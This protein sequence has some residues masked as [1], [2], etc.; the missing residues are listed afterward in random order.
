MSAKESLDPL[1]VSRESSVTDPNKIFEGLVM[2]IYPIS[3]VE[4]YNKESLAGVINSGN[5]T[6]SNSAM[7]GVDHSPQQRTSSDGH[8]PLSD[9]SG[10]SMMNAI[11]NRN[12]INNKQPG[13]KRDLAAAEMNSSKR[14]KGD[15][16]DTPNV[17]R[18]VDDSQ[19]S[20][21]LVG[22]QKKERETEEGKLMEEG[23]GVGL[24]VI[25]DDDDDIQ[26][27]DEDEI[28]EIDEEQLLDLSGEKGE[29]DQE[30]EEDNVEDDD[31]DDDDDDEDED[32]DE[33]EESIESTEVVQERRSSR[34]PC[35][36]ALALQLIGDL[37]SQITAP[38]RYN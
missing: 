2:P 13:N 17:S 23:E 27:I 10:T 7:D 4:T 36:S 32:E 8:V 33:D 3:H 24:M 35:P 9:S 1:T 19:I 20:T 29:D 15:I 25:Q 12:P 5:I 22:Q 34:P 11:L 28:F 26:E 30:N 18:S 37:P 31:D 38:P 21:S 16:Q 14:M 6:S